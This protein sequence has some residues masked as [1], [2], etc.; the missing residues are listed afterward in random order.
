MKQVLAGKRL[1]QLLAC[2]DDRNFFLDG[3]PEHRREGR[4]LTRDCHEAMRHSRRF[5]E[6]WIVLSGR[7]RMEIAGL[8]GSRL[9]PGSWSEWITDPSRPIALGEI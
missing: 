3:V 8:P 7:Y 2:L 6:G 1:P 5:M 9:Y 4:Q